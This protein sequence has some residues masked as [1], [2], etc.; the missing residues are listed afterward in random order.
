M[1]GRFISFAAFLFAGALAGAIVQGWIGAFGGLTLFAFVW[2]SIDAW[3]GQ[4]F[5]H[6]L[7]KSG[8]EPVPFTWGL[9][10]EVTDRVWRMRRESTRNLVLSDQRLNDFLAAIQASPNG[11]LLLDDEGKIEWAN[12]TAAQHLGIDVVRDHLQVLTN[13]LRSPD[14][15]NYQA[16]ADYSHDVVSAGRDDKPQRP[17][18]IAVR[19][20]PYG[21]G[22]KLMLTRDVTALEQAEAMRRDF[23]ANVSHE[24]RTPLTVIA[25]FV[26]TM[27]S[28][29]LEPQETRRYL[30]LMAGHS[31]RMKSLVEDLL[32]L[33]RLEGSPLPG[34]D[35]SVG[36]KPMWDQ[37]Q[38]EVRALSTVLM[39]SPA[40]QLDFNFPPELID[41]ELVGVP[42]EI[43]SAWSYLLS[44]AVRYTPAG[45][46]VCATAHI[47]QAGF[48]CLS[49][50]DSGPGIAPEH[51]SRLTERF[52]RV[53]SS[54]SRD[55]GG[56]G[57]GLSIVKHVIQRHGGELRIE[58]QL[59]V[60][61]HFELA[62]PAARM[63]GISPLVHAG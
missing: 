47:D 27:Q 11:V 48:F 62:F 63:R 9:W 15:L 14:F 16:Q 32:I 59:G 39:P 37:A 25:G 46:R 40:Q 49:V 52:Y 22:R 44:N 33:S 29:T 17:V 1:L 61:S 34:V 50:Q 18:R 51:L 31:Q 23:V 8:Q 5:L 24:I 19:L 28:L 12:Q 57:L 4:R 10:G 60:G 30:D 56:T 3:R 26:E 6:W 38:Q 2:W 42:S 13:L 58:S 55:L 45:G 7:Q 21:D 43:Q 36:L 53:D 54:R 20:H 35:Q 41:V